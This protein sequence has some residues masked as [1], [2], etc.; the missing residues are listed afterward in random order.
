MAHFPSG[1]DHERQCLNEKDP[2]KSEGQSLGSQM[3]ASTLNENS[4][5]SVTGRA[6]PFPVTILRWGAAAARTQRR[7][8]ASNGLAAV[9]Q[10][11]R[12]PMA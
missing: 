11:A 1:A 12:H 7:D 4:K 6:E 3:H 9:R 5:R 10:A 2:R 8:T